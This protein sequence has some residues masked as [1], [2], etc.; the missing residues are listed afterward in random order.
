[1][2][3]CVMHPPGVSMDYL[4]RLNSKQRILRFP[5][6]NL[7]ANCN[8]ERLAAAGPLF[9]TSPICAR[10]CQCGLASII[11]LGEAGFHR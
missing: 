11:R 8:I 7:A 4:Q 5:A 9:S 6:R 1:V 2:L 10:R 3:K